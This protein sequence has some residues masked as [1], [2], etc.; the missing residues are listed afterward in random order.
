MTCSGSSP[1][2]GTPFTSTS[3]SPAYSNPTVKTRMKAVAEVL[4]QHELS[5]GGEAGTL[6]YHGCGSLHLKFP[7][8]GY[9]GRHFGF[10]LYCP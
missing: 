9:A 4:S 5:W 3:L 6:T 7:Y 2:T 10:R 1:S 8:T